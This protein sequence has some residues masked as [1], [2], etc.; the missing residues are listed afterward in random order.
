MTPEDQPNQKDLE[1]KRLLEEI[2]KRAEEAELRRIEEEE[3][4]A[5]VRSL[6]PIPT[7]SVHPNTSTKELRTKELRDKLSI[8]LDRG[9]LDKA[10]ELYDE[11]WSA[12][13][14][15]AELDDFKARIDRLK[16]DLQQQAKARRRAADL[17]T[18]EDAAQQRAKREAQLKKISE[19][20]ERANAFYQQEK[21]EKGLAGVQEILALDEEN[22]DALK[23][24]EKIEKAKQLFEQ[25][26]AEE[27]RRKAEESAAAPP[28]VLEAARLPKTEAEVW[29]NRDQPAKDTGFEVPIDDEPPG[30]SKQPWIERA[31]ARLSNVQIPV[32]PLL[33]AISAATLAVVAY[34]I[35]YNIWTAVVPP[36]YSLL[37]LPARS[38]ES[39]TSLAF[40]ADGITESLIDKLSAITE[41]RVFAPQTSFA[42]NVTAARTAQITRSLGANYLVQWD[43][44]R[45]GD[46]LLLS[47]SLLDT[48][49][50]APLWSTNVQTSPRELESVLLELGKGIAVAIQVPLT[51]QEETFFSTVPEVQPK[52]YEAYAEGVSILRRSGGHSLNKAARAFARSAELDSGFAAAHAAL[53][54]TRL[55]ECETMPAAPPALITEARL[56]LQL[57][58]SIGPLSSEIYRGRGLAAQFRSDYDRALEDFE[59]AAALAPSDAEAQRRLAMIY[60]I[61]GMPDEAIKAASRAASDDPRNVESHT[62]LAMAY[63]YRAM[64]N[65]MKGND[66]RQDIHGALVSY[67]VGLSLAFDKSEYMGGLYAD[68][69]QDGQQTDRAIQ[70]LSDRVA[71]L[72]QSYIEYYKLGRLYQLAGKPKQQW[73]T[74]LDRARALLEGQLDQRP[75]DALALSYLALVRSRL[76]QFK[77]AIDANARAREL[78]STD[79]DVLYNTARMY[80][81]QREKEKSLEFLNHAIEQRYKITSILDMD[82]ST[83]RADPEF[84]STIIR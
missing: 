79:P 70:I 55:L 20:M 56:H 46:D 49:S 59:R 33:I 45:N 65:R 66:L 72:R 18:K 29:G 2:R 1:R 82:F 11:M 61:R 77:E 35:G 71:Q 7:E 19:L 76:G 43:I 9:K 78:A 48:V 25:I 57:A 69:L 31:V 40:L 27:A 67:G 83:L 84:H 63:Q 73:E 16:E 80:A 51:P 60:T 14:D 52:A 21:Y 8:A 13:P 44:G 32:K 26:K 17:K 5:G 75:D 64:V 6:T 4:K 50:S 3:Q 38:P 36:K 30:P 10:S 39:D 53:A 37:V 47:I 74:V 42:L 68:V 34:L 12:D 41:L 81:L 28:P 54:W 15:N 24:R 23:L 58:M 62:I 22:E